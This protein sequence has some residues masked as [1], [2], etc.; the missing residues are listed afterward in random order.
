MN[1]SIRLL[2]LA[3]L[4]L[5]PVVK[6]Q[7]AA[8]DKASARKDD[9]ARVAAIIDKYIAKG[10]KDNGVKPAPVAGDAEFM[11]RAYLNIA[12]RIP[13]ASEAY[14]FIS[15]KSPNKR[16]KLVAALLESPGYITH[17]T[18]F[19]SGVMLPEAQA[20][21]Q[22]RFLIPGF[23]S[24]LR[25]KLQKGERYDKLVKD[26]LTMPIDSRRNQNGVSYRMITQSSPLAFYRAKQAKPE[27]L[28]SAVSRQFLGIRIGC[29]QCHDHP[30]DSWKQ[31]QFWGVAAF[32]AGLEQQGNN[33]FGRVREVKDRRELKIPNSEKVVQATFLDGSKPQWRFRQGARDTL[34]KWVTDK[35]NPYFAKTAVNRIWGKLFGVGIVDPVDDFTSTN[36]ASHP[37]LLDALSKEFVKQDF[38]IKFLIK[39]I[40]ASKAYQLTSRKTDVSQ[41]NPQLFARMAVQGMTPEQLYD[42]LATAVGIFQPFAQQN[43]FVLGRQGSRAEILQ[44]FENTTEAPTERTT[45]ILQALAMMNGQFIANATSV[46]NSRTLTSVLEMPF[47]TTSDRI[48]S[49][50]MATLSR[51]PKPHELARMVKYVK[52]GGP[53]KNTEAAYADVFWA[54]LNS[55]EFMLNH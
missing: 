29:A 2:V 42:S 34:A 5:A 52:S 53:K 41:S 15:D 50:Y 28:A 8:D 24:W 18:T 13:R 14:A 55:S 36:V 12:G 54:L 48:E 25:G 31:E 10:W 51:K 37:E 39:A 30:H 32:F 27:N 7:A 4:M 40:T 45:T 38:D 17:Y 26:L 22:S 49:L 46:S 33:V 20:D 21:I 19:W 11:R 1:A 23:Q 6:P 43:P 9:V 16:R 35:K 3:V 47:A 44:L